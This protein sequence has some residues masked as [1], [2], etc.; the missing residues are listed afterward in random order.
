MIK[1]QHFL[2]SLEMPTSQTLIKVSHVARETL[3]LSHMGNA[4]LVCR[5]IHCPLSTR[6][7][8]P[9]VKQNLSSFNR[10]FLG[11][12]LCM[13]LRIQMNTSRFLVNTM[14]LHGLVKTS[15]LGY[16]LLRVQD[17]PFDAG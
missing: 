11:Q 4:L 13:Q 3:S 14:Q 7:L 1:Y 6:K 2:N 16:F 15:H 5:V 9:V 8:L 10:G 17:I 12:H